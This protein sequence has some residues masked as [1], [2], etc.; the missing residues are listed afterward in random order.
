V[1]PLPFGEWYS[2]MVAQSAVGKTVLIGMS[3]TM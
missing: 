3:V 1:T 2:L